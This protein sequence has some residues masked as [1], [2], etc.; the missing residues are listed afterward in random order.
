MIKNKHLTMCLHVVIFLSVIWTLISSYLSFSKGVNWPTYLK[1][2]PMVYVI[3]C[4]ILS[5]EWVFFVLG[6]IPQT[7]SQVLFFD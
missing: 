3:K 4:K 2:D 7:I 6:I 1:L 5:L